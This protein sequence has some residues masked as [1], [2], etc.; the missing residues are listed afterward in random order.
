MLRVIL[1]QPKTK[2]EERLAEK[3]AGFRLGWSTVKQIFTSQVIIEKHL[4]HQHDLCHNFLDFK[5]ASDR[6]WHEG[7]W[8]VLRSFNLE[9]GVVQAVQALFEN[10]S[11]AVL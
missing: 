2:A 10:S 6:V 7:V 9:E 5:M 11:S 8:H 4:Q 3:Q 1:S